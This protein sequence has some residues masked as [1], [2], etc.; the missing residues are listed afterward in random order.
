MHGVAHFEVDRHSFRSGFGLLLGC[1]VLVSPYPAAAQQFQVNSYTP[2]FVANPR[3]ATTPDGG[4]V[5]VWQDTG[6]N[7]NP[8]YKARMRW[9]D[10]DGVPLAAETQICPGGWGCHLPAVAVNSAGTALVV[11]GAVSGSQAGIFARRYDSAGQP[12][13]SWT[14]LNGTVTGGG[15]PDVAARPDNGFVVVW[16]QFPNGGSFDIAGRRVGPGGGVQGSVIGVNNYTPG[17]QNRPR[18]AVAADGRFL[19]TWDSAAA[20]GDPAGWSV[21]G[22]SFD[23]TGVSLGPQFQ[24]NTYTTGNQY[25]PHIAPVGSDDFIVAWRS[26]ESSMDTVKASWRD[27]SGSAQHPE[28]RVDDLWAGSS[29]RWVS[30]AASPSSPNEFTSVWL[31]S[32]AVK[33]RRFD[34]R[35]APISSAF[36]I[37]ADLDGD[38]VYAPH[39]AADSAGGLVVV[40]EGYRSVGNDPNGSIQGRHFPLLFEGTFESGG[41]EDWTLVFP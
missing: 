36:R 35:G 16:S 1:F 13:G 39:V 32:G 26:D 23:A 6:S 28:Y 40:W 3:V 9:F 19:V 4:F 22:R 27:I 12:L 41:L 30:V 7:P 31:Q 15:F 17:E 8:E 5:V 38:T 18:V 10:S 24:V 25:Y 20:P 34:L 11:M 21:H 29:A 33:V 14:Y 2:N 37:D